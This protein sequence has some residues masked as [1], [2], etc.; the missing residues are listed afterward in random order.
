MAYAAANS[1][2][3]NPP[4]MVLQPIA[5]GGGSTYNSTVSSSLIG[6]KL[7]IYVSTHLQAAFGTSDFV[8]DGLKLGMKPGDMVLNNVIGGAVSFHRVVSL[9]STSVTFSA[10]LMVSSAS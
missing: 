2:S 3:P 5:L 4:S 9:T 6:G 1:S 7:W 8:T 10:G